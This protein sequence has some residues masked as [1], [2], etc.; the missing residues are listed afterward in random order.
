MCT[1][2]LVLCGTEGHI[3]GSMCARQSKFSAN[4]AP[5]RPGIIIVVVVVGIMGG[6]S[7]D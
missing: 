5:S 1:I 3:Q 6:P 7:T 2:S 4:R